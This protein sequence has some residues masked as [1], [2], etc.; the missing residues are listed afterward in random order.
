M[1]YI[2]CVSAIGRRNTHFCKRIRRNGSWPMGG[3]THSKTN[4]KMFWCSVFFSLHSFFSFATAVVAITRGDTRVTVREIVKFIS[5]DFA[6]CWPLPL[7]HWVSRILHTHSFV[8][9]ITHSIANARKYNVNFPS[10]FLSLFYYFSLG[11]HYDEF[12]R[13]VKV[14]VALLMPCDY[15]RCRGTRGYA[16]TLLDMHKSYAFQ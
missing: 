9:F 4:D 5:L 8:T 6:I 14:T 2:L 16:R 3:C 12:V 15:S 1:S 10:L 11:K 13:S 7:S